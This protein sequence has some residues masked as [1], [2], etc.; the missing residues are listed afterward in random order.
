M[1]MREVQAKRDFAIEATVLL[2][3][4]LHCIWTLPEE[5]HDFSTRWRL[6]KGRFTRL[7]L[8]SGG[9]E[10][11]RGASRDGRGERGV[12]QRRFWEH[13]VRN[14]NELAALFDYIHDNP[15]KHGH[16]DC[17]H[18]WPHSSF[19]RLVRGGVYDNDWQCICS[20]RSREGGARSTL[21]AFD[22]VAGLAGE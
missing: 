4:H 3:D 14:E 22:Q 10:G 12:W 19:H 13:T 9:K 18:E 20:D 15:V 6:V 7:Y 21:R 17:P 1:A 2:P 11:T 5:G 16:A 8:G